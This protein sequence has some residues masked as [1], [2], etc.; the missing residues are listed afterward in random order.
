MKAE[1]T[2]LRFQISSFLLVIRASRLWI[3][4]SSLQEAF[5]STLLDF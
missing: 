1:K 5:S 2:E 3:F 4:L